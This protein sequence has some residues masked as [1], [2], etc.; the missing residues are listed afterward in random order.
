MTRWL[1]PAAI[2]RLAAD[3]ARRMRMRP[4]DA[5]DL[6]KPFVPEEYTQLYYTP[7]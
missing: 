6:R 7:L 1:D 4:L 3:P 5:I 2:E